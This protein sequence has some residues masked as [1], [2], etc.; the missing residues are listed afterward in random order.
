MLQEQSVSK[1]PGSRT[2]PKHLHPSVAGFLERSHCT[3][4][5]P[6]ARLF[7]NLAVRKAVRKKLRG[8]LP[9]WRRRLASE[10]P[11]KAG[12]HLERCPQ[13]FQG[14]STSPTIPGVRSTPLETG[15]RV[16]CVNLRGSTEIGPTE[17]A[18]HP[19][20]THAVH[21]LLPKPQTRR[22]RLTRWLNARPLAGRPRTTRQRRTAPRSVSSTDLPM[23]PSRDRPSVLTCLCGSLRTHLKF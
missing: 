15:G 7:D 20:P 16:I 9:A 22:Q 8:T 21:A 2:L 18:P 4:L 6:R 5:L 12:D 11:G 10:A 23:R 14:F 1:V 17:I 3:P 19:A 13:R